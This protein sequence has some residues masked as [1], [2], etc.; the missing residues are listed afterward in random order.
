MSRAPDGTYTIPLPPVVTDTLIEATWANTSL[1]DIET[2]L[3][4]SLSRS[5]KGGMSAALKVAD[6]TISAPGVAFT[7]A[8]STGLYRAGAGDFRVSVLGVD[9]MRW[10]STLGTQIWDGSAWNAIWNTREPLTAA[11]TYYVRT[12]GDDANDGLADTAGGAFL[13]I[14][15][16]WDII[17]QTLDTQ[18]YQVTIKVADGTYTSGIE[19]KI[20]I[21]GG[22]NV[23]V[24]LTGNTTTPSNCIISTTSANCI[25]INGPAYL[26]VDGFKLT[27]TTSGHTVA[28]VTGRV[29]LYKI[30]FA[31][32]AGYHIYATGREDT[33]IVLFDD[34]S[35]TGAADNHMVSSNGQIIVN[36]VTCTIAGNP[37]FGYFALATRHGLIYSSAVYSGACTGTRYRAQDEAFISTIT[38]SATFFPGDVDGVI[39]QNASYNTHTAHREPLVA[40]RTYYVRTD[41]DDA[42]T[43][44]ANTAGGAFLTIQRAVDVCG[45][46]LDFR[47]YVVTV[48]VGAGTY[49]EKVQIP[50]MTGIDTSATAV[51]QFQIIGDATTPSNVVV[52]GSSF[53][54]CFVTVSGRAY[55]S[56]FKVINSTNTGILASAQAYIQLGVMEYGACSQNHIFVINQSFV[57][58][59]DDYAITGNAATHL[60]VQG[61]SVLQMTNSTVTLT[62]PPAFTTFA[63]ATTGGVLNIDGNTYSGS[64]TGNYYLATVNGVIFVNGA[65]ATYLPGNAAGSTLTGGQYV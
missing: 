30:D 19:A 57:K 24:A 49:A 46:T 35:I 26:K 65:G 37:A 60:V 43:G 54:A 25:F 14:Q 56:G 18:G 59:T 36:S 28:A 32:C 1:S 31:A 51:P 22:G 42:N 23:P 3:T 52:D 5:G 8:A 13:T 29:D 9:Q 12:D 15:H 58:C 20:A 2:A 34:Y 45:D 40:D 63:Y 62:G 47:G 41:G 53:V 27:T 55:I 6:G 7:S 17:A 39:V 50:F 61:N 33:S 38:D 4:D 11:R 10:S 64:A 48:N 44:L 21:T 16:A